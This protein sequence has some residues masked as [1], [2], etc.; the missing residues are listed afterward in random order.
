MT[1]GLPKA[2][3]RTVAVVN[4]ASS[5]GRT[6]RRWPDLRAA[7]VRAGVQFDERITD[8]PGQATALT[9]RCLTE[10]FDRVI[11]VGGDGTANEVVNGFFDRDGDAISGRNTLCL[12]P[13]GTGGDLRRS[14]GIPL[15]A[16]GAAALIAEGR[17]RPIDV[18]RVEFKDGTPPRFFINVADCGLGGEVTRRVNAGSHVGSGKLNFLWASLASMMTFGPRQAII[19]VDGE[20]LERNVQTVV[21]ANNRFFGGGMEIAP[22]AIDEDGLL[23]LVIVGA[24]PR[25]RSMLELRRLYSGSHIGRPGIETRRAR[26]VTVTPAGGGE[27]RFEIDGE[28]TGV[29]PATV[30][31]LRHALQV[32]A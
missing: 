15:S 22:Q 30:R 3:H 20:I 10:G 13:S 12:M 5:G 17:S 14:L 28:P 24:M 26:A 19:E 7:L 31:C 8:A 9:R 32:C 21:M 27:L 4:P 2:G 23:D 6:G 16:Q 29:A 1:L 25:R 18:G 11:A